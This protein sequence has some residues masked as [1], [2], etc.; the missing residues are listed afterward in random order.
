MN[1]DLRIM[2][3]AVDGGFIGYYKDGGR[4][5]DVNIYWLEKLGLK[6]YLLPI[7]ESH[8]IHAMREYLMQRNIIRRLYSNV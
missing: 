3:L 7:L 8:N 4:W 1:D 2:L 5:K 6:E